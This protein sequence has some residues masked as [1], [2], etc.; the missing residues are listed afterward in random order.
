MLQNQNVHLQ[1]ESI[2]SCKYDKQKKLQFF[3][4]CCF[5]QWDNLRIV[6]MQFIFI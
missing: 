4:T 6:R 2:D 3:E 5:V 1:I